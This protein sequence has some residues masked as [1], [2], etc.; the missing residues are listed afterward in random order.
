MLPHMRPRLASDDCADVRLRDAEQ[1]GC[2]L[3]AQS[4][5]ADCPHVTFGKLGGAHLVATHDAFRRYPTVM[6]VATRDA[7]RASA[8]STA[9]SARQ[10][11]RLSAAAVRLAGS[12]PPA[13]NFVGHIVCVAAPAKMRRVAARFVVAGMK[14]KRPIGLALARH[15]QGNVRR[16]SPPPTAPYLTTPALIVPRPWPAFVIAAPFN[17]CPKAGFHIGRNHVRGNVSHGAVPSRGGQ[18]RTALQP[19]CRPVFPVA[20]RAF[21]QGFAA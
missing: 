7:F 2:G 11:F 6:P 10:S 17:Q 12:A 18:G 4:G 8:A 19:L 14:R 5:S 13:R 15:Q 9:I 21:C 16:I 20:K 3:L 1:R